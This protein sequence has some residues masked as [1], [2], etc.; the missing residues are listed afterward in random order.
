MPEM[1]PEAVMSPRFLYN[2]I[3]NPSVIAR[4]Y[5][6]T[7]DKASFFQSKC[8]NLKSGVV[9]SPV[10]A[11]MAPTQTLNIVPNTRSGFK[12][13]QNEEAVDID[14]DDDRRDAKDTSLRFTELVPEMDYT[15]SFGISMRDLEFISCSDVRN[16]RAIG[17]SSDENKANEL[18]DMYFKALKRNFGVENAPTDIK[19]YY[20]IS[21]AA[22]DSTCEEGYVLT[23]ELRVS[24]AK[25]VLTE[26]IESLDM[27]TRPS[28]GTMLWM[29]NMDMELFYDDGTSE[30]INNVTKETIANISF[31]PK[32]YY[33]LADEEY[34]K[35]REA[36]I[37]ATL[38][39]KKATK[40]SGKKTTKT[41]DDGE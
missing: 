30:V 1:Y 9:I 34:L 26:M 37:K 11:D 18:K 31:S 25:R 7:T 28:A 39:Q 5:M 13:I 12:K 8:L 29:K 10:V 33:A 2:L 3:T 27:Q 4:G 22:K 35:E 6:F 19:P 32:S 36:D 20:L 17:F 14:D 16:Q 21:N 15:A 41:E 38:N 40:K 23:D 24:L